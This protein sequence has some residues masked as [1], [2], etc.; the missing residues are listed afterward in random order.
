MVYLM[1]H[2][3]LVGYLPPDEFHDILLINAF[4][5]LIVQSELQFIFV[6]VQ[7]LK[8]GA[9]YNILQLLDCGVYL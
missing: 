1:L 8:D 3:N 4:S 9:D 2:N 7:S 6:H 5:L